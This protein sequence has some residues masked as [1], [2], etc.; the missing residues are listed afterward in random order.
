MTDTS[1]ILQFAADD[2]SPMGSGLWRSKIFRAPRKICPSVCRISFAEGDL[3]DHQALIDARKEA[4]K[5]NQ[6]KIAAGLA[7][8]PGGGWTFAELC[9]GGDVLETVPDEPTYTG[10]L[11]LTFRL[12]GDGTL[13]HTETVYDGLFRLTGRYRA[14]EFY[15]EIEGNVD[16]VSM[17]EIATSMKELRAE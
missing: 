4:I 17:V 9:I 10:S 3:A 14:T 16:S 12:Y 13:R 6:A 11:S 1:Y 8:E 7:T 2:S 5:R 15:Y